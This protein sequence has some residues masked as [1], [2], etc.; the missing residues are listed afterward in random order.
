VAESNGDSDGSILNGRL[1]DFRFPRARGISLGPEAR[2]LVGMGSLLVLVAVAILAAV[3]LMV[4]LNDDATQ[5]TDNQVQY[6]TAIDAAALNAKAMANHERGFLL[7]GNPEFIREI[8]RETGK[9][10]AALIVAANEATGTA[11]YDA[12]IEANA[13]FERWVVA[14]RR[15]TERFQAGDREQAVKTSLGPT[16][17]LRKS[18]ERSLARAQALGVDAV[19]SA[20]SSVS[21]AARISIA[22]LL[23]Y[24]VFALA[25]G[26]LV[27]WWVVR[28]ALR[29]AREPAELDVDHERVQII[30]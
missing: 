12:V 23:G 10:R 18:Y 16:R 6:A 17:A 27:T 19:Q 26:I 15:E 20:R 7:S 30:K 29:S 3:L 1:R 8:D 22:I 25:V 5:L 13:G 21:S 14:L 24:L 4:G 9:A 11:Q 28:T 2:V